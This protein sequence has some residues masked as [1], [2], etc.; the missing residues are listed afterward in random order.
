MKFFNK[1]PDSIPIRLHAALEGLANA[2]GM[3][4]SKLTVGLQEHPG[5][6]LR[7]ESRTIVPVCQGEKAV[8]WEVPALSSLFR[9]ERK[10][11]ADMKEYPPFYVPAFHL[12][13]T[14][15]LVLCR[16]KGDRTDQEMEE[17]YSTLRRRP[18]GRSLGFTHDFMWQV[19]ALMLG[20]FELS[21]EEYLAVVG[22]LEASV[23]AW[24][25]RPVS[26]FYSGYLKQAFG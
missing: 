7:I 16:A 18:D 21:E 13:E 10:P 15:V 9:G 6:L 19:C 22:R 26:R 1:T 5:G 24:A 8:M 17:I 2:Q 14:H 3:E 11:P 20:K 4:P 12:V 25:L 23:R